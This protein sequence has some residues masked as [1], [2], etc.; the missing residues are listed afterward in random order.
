MS[1]NIHKKI[2]TVLW[3]VATLFLCHSDA[4][5]FYYGSDK[6]VG[7]AGA[8]SAVADDCSAIYMNPAGMSQTSAYVFDLNYQVD[9]SIDSKLW[10]VSIIDSTTGPVALGLGYYKAGRDDDVWAAKERAFGHDYSN[11][12]DREELFSIALSEMYSPSFFVGFAY[13]YIK[14]RSEQ[15]DDDSIDAGLLY[16]LNPQISFALVGKNLMDTEFKEY[17]KLYTAGIAYKASN[18]LNLS[19]DITKD[20]TT[21]KENDV[22]YS[23]AAEIF[24]FSSLFLR[25]GYM[26]DKIQERKFYAVGVSY[27]TSGFSLG[28]AIMRDEVDKTNILHT[29]SLKLI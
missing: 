1:F 19:F 17:H 18:M 8:Y 7:L 11:L 13:K 15:D 20:D 29:F 23:Y 28:Y 5:P 14:Q 27:I 9:K 2:N 26:I 24:T 21:K 22:T 25:G 12:S 10:G 3:I 16:R 6:P 4:Y